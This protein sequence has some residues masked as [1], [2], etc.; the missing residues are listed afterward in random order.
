MVAPK[1]IPC[2][3]KPLFHGTHFLKITHES[4]QSTNSACPSRP[5][6][7]SGFRPVSTAAIS[8]LVTSLL[9]LPAPTI[10]HRLPHR[11]QSAP[12][13]PGSCHLHS[14]PPQGQ[15]AAGGSAA[16][17]PPSEGRIGRGQLLCCSPARSDP[18]VVRPALSSSCP[19][20]LWHICT[21]NTALARGPL[22]TPGPLP[23]SAVVGQSAPSQPVSAPCLPCHLGCLFPG[24]HAPRP[25]TGPPSP[26]LLGP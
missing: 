25:M 19:A 24:R 12:N 2:P 9:L 16:S 4:R 11:R 3:E 21:S 23:T 8:L 1:H 13:L 15:G 5:G 14:Q 18:P 17:P 6:G 7:S 22:P 26:L 10:D 20:Q